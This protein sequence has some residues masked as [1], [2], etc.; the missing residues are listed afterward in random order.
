M[1]NVTPGDMRAIIQSQ[2]NGAPG[3]G[4]ACIDLLNRMWDCRTKRR[5]SAKQVLSTLLA[6]PLPLPARKCW[7]TPLSLN[8]MAAEQVLAHPWM[9]ECAKKPQ[10]DEVEQQVLFSR[11]RFRRSRPALHAP[12]TCP[13]DFDAHKICARIDDP[14]HPF[15]TNAQTCTQTHKESMRVRVHVDSYTCT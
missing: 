5:I 8:A 2:E 3:G 9:T 11:L 14:I 6:R 7:A 12:C 10:V 13:Q 4:L 15:N 1:G